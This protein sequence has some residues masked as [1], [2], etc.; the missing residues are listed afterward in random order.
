MAG[1]DALSPTPS[2]SAIIPPPP[3]L[4]P[5]KASSY[6]SRFVTQPLTTAAYGSRPP[7]AQTNRP[8]GGRPNPLVP[9]LPG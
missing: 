5:S 3:P 6:F 4:P 7:S 2:G 1:G 8:D 9:R